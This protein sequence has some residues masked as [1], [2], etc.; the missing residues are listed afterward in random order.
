M[1][2]LGTR[3]EA[4]KVAP[5]VLE[6][7]KY[8][9]RFKVDLVWSGQ[10]AKLARPFLK[11]FN[12]RPNCDFNIMKPNQ[13]LAGIVSAVSLKLNE[14]INKSKPD[15]I[16][17]QGDTTTAFV[18]ALCGYYN[19]VPVA[20]LEAGLRSFNAYHP[21]PEEK[22]RELLS[23]L[24][25]WNFAPTNYAKKNLLR[26]GINP[27]AIYVVGNSVVDA[28]HWLLKRYPP[29]KQNWDG[30]L[31]VVTA[32]RRESFGEPLKN[33]CKAVAALVKKHEDLK[34]VFPVHPNPCVRHVVMKTLGRLDRVELAPPM[35]Y[36][37][38]IHLLAN[39][40]AALTDSG[41]VQEE[42]PCLGKPV[43]ITREVT[44]RPEGVMAGASKVVGREMGN[45][46][47]A[48]EKLLFNPKE[49]SQ[50]ARVRYPFGRGDT[51]KQVV[52]VLNKSF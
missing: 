41:G 40:S 8:P 3:P 37:E 5:V 28:I 36:L 46:I 2:V 15:V 22:N 29:P 21:F 20:H 34:V 9:K 32:H 24:A 43:L 48:V 16:L 45:I 7:Q 50:M 19:K 35:D 26:E 27:K 4:V 38:F 14:H 25:E 31:L 1:A 11:M 23:H 33:I 49:Y 51:S 17:V 13:T 12:L 44:E 18:S 10:H 42:A 30:K 6:L 47:S 39:C 52:E